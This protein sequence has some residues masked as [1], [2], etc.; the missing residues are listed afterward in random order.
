MK[1]IM[2][3]NYKIL[4]YSFDNDEIKC[5]CNFDYEE[6]CLSCCDIYKSYLELYKQMI[7]KNVSI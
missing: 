6:N 3:T 5:L 1:A 4:I 7:S 2:N